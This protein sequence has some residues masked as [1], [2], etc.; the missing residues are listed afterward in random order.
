MFRNLKNSRH[1]KNLGL[2]QASSHHEAQL[3]IIGIYQACSF[4]DLSGG[5]M[6]QSILQKTII[7]IVYTIIKFKTNVDFDKP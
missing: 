3:D 6:I 7:F 5:K 1:E 4:Q 2:I